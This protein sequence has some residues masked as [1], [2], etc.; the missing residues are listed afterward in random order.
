MRSLDRHLSPCGG[1]EWSLYREINVY[2]ASARVSELDQ[3]LGF[4]LQLQTMLLDL[5]NNVWSGVEW[6]LAS[7]SGLRKHNYALLLSQYPHLLCD[8]PENQPRNDFLLSLFLALC[9]K[10]ILQEHHML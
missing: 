3:V 4:C 8:S 7:G 6:R 5:A 10:M 1:L 2:P 9:Y